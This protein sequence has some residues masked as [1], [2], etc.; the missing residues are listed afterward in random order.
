[1]RD[2]PLDPWLNRISVVAGWRP[3]RSWQR[4]SELRRY[5]EAEEGFRKTLEAKIRVDGAEHPNTLITMNALGSVLVLRGNYEE[6][7]SLIRRL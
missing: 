7:E 2:F 5:E 4:L 3:S 1:M 6:A